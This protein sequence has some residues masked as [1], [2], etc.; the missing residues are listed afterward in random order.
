MYIF[1]IP[2]IR[3]IKGLFKLADKDNDKTLTFKEVQ[4]LLK[5][6]NVNA[7]ETIARNYFQVRIIHYRCHHKTVY[8]NY[9]FCTRI[10]EI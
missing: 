4:G 1:L 9:M 3:W 7:D 6:L 5:H 2:N 10:Q 8:K